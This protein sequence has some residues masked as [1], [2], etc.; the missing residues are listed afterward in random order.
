MPN[1]DFVSFLTR[2]VI[3]LIAAL[4]VHCA[5]RYRVLDGVDGFIWKWVVGWVGAWLGTPVLGNWFS[6]VKISHIYIIPGFLG[7]FI[8]AFI[9]AAVWKAGAKVAAQRTS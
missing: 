9:A 4:I 3:S 7:G 5:I 2:L 6:H 8:G 1:L